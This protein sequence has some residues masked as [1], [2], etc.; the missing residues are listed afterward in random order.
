MAQKAKAVREV[1]QLHSQNEVNSF[2]FKTLPPQGFSPA[3]LLGD[4]AIRRNA[5]SPYYIVNVIEKA[6][7]GSGGGMTRLDTGARNKIW[8]SRTSFLE[9]IYT[10]RNRFRRVEG[11]PATS[12]SVILS[13]AAQPKRRTNS[14]RLVVSPFRRFVSNLLDWGYRVRHYLGA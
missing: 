11:D 10:S 1:E 9:G 5:L 14:C 12:R 7:G 13:T 8:S 6:D 4:K 3:I 2:S